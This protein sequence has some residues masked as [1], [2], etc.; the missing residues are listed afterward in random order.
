ML[1]REAYVE[2][3]SLPRVFRRDKGICQICGLPVPMD[4]SPENIWGATV[5]HI[6]PLSVGG[7]HSMKNCQL[8]HRLCNSIK[9]QESFTE[10]DWESIAEGNELAA[11]R[12]DEL[13]MQIGSKR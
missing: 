12:L 4:T 3:V 1:I 11:E 5:D 13:F 10:V 7:E 9:G 6:V 8:S 2:P